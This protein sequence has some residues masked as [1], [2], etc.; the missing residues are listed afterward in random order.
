MQQKTLPGCLRKRGPGV[1]TM[2]K[3]SDSFLMVM[4]AI[5]RIHT[6]CGVQNLSVILGRMKNI[7][8][9]EIQS[10]KDQPIKSVLC[11]F[12]DVK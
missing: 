2:K 1:F 6:T 11:S 4:V 5:C 9:I 12:P 3:N 10:W 7:D 8:R